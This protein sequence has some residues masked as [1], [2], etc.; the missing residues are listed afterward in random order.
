MPERFSNVKSGFMSANNCSDI[1]CINIQELFIDHTVYVKYALA[2]LY[3]LHWTSVTLMFASSSTRAFRMI[4]KVRAFLDALLHQE[5][6][7]SVDVYAYMF[8][9]DFFNFF[10][11]IIGFSA[12]GVR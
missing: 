12:F 11:L 4:G 5:T 1:T 9:C 10:V 6:Q 3:A 7:V 2:V 8:F